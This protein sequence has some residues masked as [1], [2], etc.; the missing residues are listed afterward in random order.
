MTNTR[1]EG[2]VKTQ[3]HLFAR[4]LVK[5]NFLEAFNCEGAFQ[6]LLNK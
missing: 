4:T 1:R 5:Q 3:F 6:N 2:Q